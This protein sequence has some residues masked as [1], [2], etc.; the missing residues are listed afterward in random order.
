VA[1]PPPSDSGQSSPQRFQR[2][3]ED[4]DQA[5]KTGGRSVRNPRIQEA[6][7]ER[8]SG[9]R[10][11]MNPGRTSTRMSGQVLDMNRTVPFTHHPAGVCVFFL[12]VII[13]VLSTPYSVLRMY[14]LSGRNVSRL[15]HA[16]Q[17]ASRTCRHHHLLCRHLDSIESPFNVTENAS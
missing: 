16:V 12:A 15:T 6:R 14:L 9:I 8:V 5:S 1:C 13:V 2:S 10:G 4:H 17:Q 11:K 7:D 3:N